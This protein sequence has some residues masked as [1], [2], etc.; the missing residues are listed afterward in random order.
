MQ[1][2]LGF[3]TIFGLSMVLFDAFLTQRERNRLHHRLIQTWDYLDDL[4]LPTV[5]RESLEY[6]LRRVDDFV[7]YGSFNIRGWT[8]FVKC[9]LL[10]TLAV[11]ALVLPF[12]LLNINEPTGLKVGY[13]VRDLYLSL[14]S[15]PHGDTS[16]LRSSLERVENQIAEYE[17]IHQSGQTWRLNMDQLASAGLLAVALLVVAPAIAYLSLGVTRMLVKRAS[18]SAVIPT[19][20]SLLCLDCVA[21]LLFASLVVWSYNGIAILVSSGYYTRPGSILYQ[22]PLSLSDT[23]PGLELMFL[24]DT[25]SDRLHAA[26]GMWERLSVIL[27][28]TLKMWWSYLQDVYAFL[29]TDWTRVSYPEAIRNWGFTLSLFPTAMYLAMMLFTSIFSRAEPLQRGLVKFL[30]W[31]AERERWTLAKSGAAIAGLCQAIRA[32]FF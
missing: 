2:L 26:H 14:L 3:L 31:S 18:H 27:S 11:F 22:M 17:T 19:T 4:D 29:S 32:A 23:V 8:F 28:T 10:L 30:A 20:V 13:A 9:Q 16:D 15:D 25:L 7:G 24:G 1:D 5:V 21:A 12:V 6:F